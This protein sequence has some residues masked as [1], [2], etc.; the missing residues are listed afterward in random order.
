M[1]RIAMKFPAN[2]FFML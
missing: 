1:T 2:E